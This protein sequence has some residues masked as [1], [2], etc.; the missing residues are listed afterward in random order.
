MRKNISFNQTI[1]FLYPRKSNCNPISYS[2]TNGSNSPPL[3]FRVILYCLFES[4]SLMKALFQ[5]L[6]LEELLE[7]SLTLRRTLET[8]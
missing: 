8:A 2:I 7:I 5:P 3:L 1:Y 4:K 6:V